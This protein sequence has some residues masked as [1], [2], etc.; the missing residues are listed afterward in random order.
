MILDRESGVILELWWDGKAS[1]KINVNKRIV[2]LGHFQKLLQSINK[3]LDIF[4]LH[5]QKAL[6]VVDFQEEHNKFLNA[7]NNVVNEY[8]FIIIDDQSNTKTKKIHIRRQ[9]WKNFGFELI[10]G[11]RATFTVKVDKSWITKGLAGG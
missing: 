5:F 2:K 11:G 10:Y 3:R 1:E 4:G 9:N 7:T 8:P 6:I